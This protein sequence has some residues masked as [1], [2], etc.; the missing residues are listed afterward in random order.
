V[1][2]LNLYLPVTSAV[3]NFNRPSAPGVTGSE[4]PFRHNQRGGLHGRRGP[5]SHL[6]RQACR[7]NRQGCAR[8][9][10]DTRRALAALPKV[11]PMTRWSC[12]C[13]ITLQHEWRT[14]VGSSSNS[15]RWVEIKAVGQGRSRRGG[16]INRHRRHF[17]V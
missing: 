7:S 2:P 5:Q 4:K 1:V 17:L 10:R 15:S 16:S 3:S 14:R 12:S 9:N 11:R 6:P 8:T 13:G